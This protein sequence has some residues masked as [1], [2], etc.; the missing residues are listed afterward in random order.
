MRARP[1]SKQS[2]QAGVVEAGRMGADVLLIHTWMAS[3]LSP[4]T[5]K[6]RQD[7]GRTRIISSLG[8]HHGA[9]AQEPERGWQWGGGGRALVNVTCT[10]SQALLG[11][12]SLGKG[13][14]L[15]EP[16]LPSGKTQG[17]NSN[18]HRGCRE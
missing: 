4:D 15:P 18:H 12:T 9:Q 8:G 5:E 7:L 10:K 3:R 16:Q 17:D 14:D 2:E 6:D 13:L 11:S 1:P